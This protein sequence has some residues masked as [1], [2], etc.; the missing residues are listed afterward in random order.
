M[1]TKKKNWIFSLVRYLL[2]G[3]LSFFAGYYF[4]AKKTENKELVV[5][6]PVKIKETEEI[7]ETED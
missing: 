7:K 1:R 4:K 5:I 6:V 3:F 2:L